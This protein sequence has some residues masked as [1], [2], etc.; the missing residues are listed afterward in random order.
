MYPS[1]DDGIQS[2][3]IDAIPIRRASK[4]N[5]AEGA[6]DDGEAYDVRESFH[7]SSSGQTPRALSV[8]HVAFQCHK[9]AVARAGFSPA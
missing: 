2:L 8:Y 3:K 9:P 5:A 4:T 7:G 6:Q 1:S